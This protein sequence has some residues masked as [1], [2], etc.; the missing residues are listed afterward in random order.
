MPASYI[1]MIDRK[2]AGKITAGAIIVVI[3]GISIEFFFPNINS[4][5]AGDKVKSN[6]AITD[7]IR[8]KNN[9]K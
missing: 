5:K 9:D 4:R 1:D 8:I 2:T 7:P 3:I 6:K